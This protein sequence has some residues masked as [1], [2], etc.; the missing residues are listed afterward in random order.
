MQR[1]NLGSG[2]KKAG[3]MIAGLM[4]SWF[5]LF[6]VYLFFTKTSVAAKLLAGGSFIL[7]LLLVIPFWIKIFKNL[8]QDSG[9]Q[10]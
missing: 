5:L 2:N 1:D 10:S 6:D 8:K 4:L 7:L 3:Q 9:F